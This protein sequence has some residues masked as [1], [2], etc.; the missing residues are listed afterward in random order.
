MKTKL[1]EFVFNN[2]W[3]IGFNLLALYLFAKMAEEVIEKE[4]IV[5]IDRWISI[6]V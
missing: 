3:L 4:Y 2:K 6:H 5:V 1:L